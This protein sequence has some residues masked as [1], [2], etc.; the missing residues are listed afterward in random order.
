MASVSFP[1]AVTD[2]P[3]EQLKGEKA[4]S[5]RGIVCH[6]EEGMAGGRD[7]GYLQDTSISSLSVVRETKVRVF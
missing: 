2:Y 4:Y 7:S 5:S 1:L 3:D 6:G